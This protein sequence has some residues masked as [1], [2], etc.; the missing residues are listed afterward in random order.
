M[1]SRVKLDKAGRVVLPKTVR[2]QLQL[3]A[4]DILELESYGKEITLRRVAGHAQLHK[5]FGV[6]VFRSCEPLTNEMVQKA[7]RRVR[8]ERQRQIVG[9]HL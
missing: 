5:K 7:V 2:D 9:K 1:V 4:G 3:R 6:W 8:D